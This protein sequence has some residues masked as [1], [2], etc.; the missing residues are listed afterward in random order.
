M[1]NMTVTKQGHETG[2]NFVILNT[3]L[4]AKRG[5]FD[6]NTQVHKA[7]DNSKHQ[8]NFAAL[9]LEGAVSILRWHKEKGRN[10]R[11]NF[12]FNFFRNG[13]G[14]WEEQS[15]PSIRLLK[16]Q[17]FWLIRHWCRHPQV[18]RILKNILALFCSAWWVSDP[19]LLVNP[20]WNWEEQVIHMHIAT[21][22]ATSYF[23]F[24]HF[25]QEVPSPSLFVKLRKSFLSSFWQ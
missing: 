6:D 20:H 3:K 4:L 12:N 19:F 15:R 5:P 25:E 16:S 2:K 8:E 1:L 22:Y 13:K 9:C 17:S 7:T 18:R 14:C 10:C 21:F 11:P 24:S 23:H